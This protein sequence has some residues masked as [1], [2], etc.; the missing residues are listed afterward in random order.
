MILLDFIGFQMRKV[1][2]NFC[3]RDEDRQGFL[4]IIVKN[5]FLSVGYFD[6]FYIVGVFRFYNVWVIVVY[7]GGYFSRGN[8]GVYTV[9]VLWRFYINVQYWG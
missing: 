3:F 6:K 4:G 7:E 2:K 8:L 5:R 1:R 9:L